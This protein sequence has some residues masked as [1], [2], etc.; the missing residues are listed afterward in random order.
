VPHYEVDPSWP[1]KLPNNWVMGVPS[2]VAV[3]RHDHVFVL[4]R[5]RLVPA[6]LR[7]HAAPPV[8][9]L[10][11]AGTF[12][13]AWGGPGE[14]FDWPDSE[15]G[16]FVD[17]R[18]R[19]WITG[20]NP[21]GGG[22][23]PRHDDM[24]LTFTRDGRFIQQIGGRNVAGGSKD[25]KNPHQPAVVFVYDKTNEVFVADGYGNRRILVL[26]AD[27][28]A[29]KRQW[30]AFGKEPQ[31]PL[32]RPSSAAA[33]STTTP[34]DQTGPGPDRFNIVH[35]LRVAND[36][37]VY[38]ADPGNR[39]IQVF[40][41]EG[42]Y[43]TQGFVNRATSTWA[44]ST[45]AFSPDR[46]QRH[47]FCPDLGRAEIAIVDRRSFERLGA[48]GSRGAGPGQFQSVHSVAADSKGNI[49]VPEVPPGRR[50]Q[51]FVRKATR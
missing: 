23:S 28:G 44:C 35:G 30:G 10:D 49:Y 41:L 51:K 37:L 48:V 5:P 26:D 25:T 16:I 6:D 11:S 14:G 39:R 32:P 40:T 29:F 43:L 46:E 47:I 17:H 15:H 18:D 13:R 22:D 8:I 24:I 2:W 20:N 36:G 12:V 33:R 19:V 9:E 38:V 45:V 42:K 1:P 31:D 3:D 27:T 4:H 7:A 21:Y 50:L 34:E